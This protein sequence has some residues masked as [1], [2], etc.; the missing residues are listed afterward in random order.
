MAYAALT[1]VQG[2]VA[3][4]PITPTSKPNETQVGTIITGIAAEIDTAIAN[5]GYAVP[6]ASP[7]SFLEYLTL[8]N[9]YGA[10]S[11]AIRSIFADKTGSAEG[12]E[13]GIEAYYAAQYAKGL[14][15]LRDGSGIPPGVSTTSASI[16]PS[17]YFTRNP[18][19]EEDLGD[20]AEPFFKRETVF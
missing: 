18:D 12:F 4:F 16:G 9:A 11:A 5:A 2:L 8:L 1:D 15:S 13:G 7:A 14:A 20:I 19:A 3:K 6:V 10:A 17:T